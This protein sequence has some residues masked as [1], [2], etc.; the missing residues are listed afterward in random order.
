MSVR[1]FPGPSRPQSCARLQFSAMT[2]LYCPVIRSTVVMLLK[3][4]V[5]SIPV[6]KS[7]PDDGVFHRDIQP[8]SI[9]NPHLVTRKLK[10]S[11]QSALYMRLYERGQE[12]GTTD[13]T[14]PQKTTKTVCGR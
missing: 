12:F 8:R 3:G 2:T 13:I 10:D 9:L 11:I 5:F 6:F 1:N 14:D 4:R 7:L